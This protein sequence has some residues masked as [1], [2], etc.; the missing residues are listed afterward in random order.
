M[1]DN[2]IIYGLDEIDMLAIQ[3]IKRA[4]HKTILFKG[5]MGSGKTTLIKAIGKKLGVSQKIASPTYSIVNEYEISDGFVYHFDLYRL[6]N[7]EE[8]L[9]FGIEEYLFSEHWKLIE[10][11]DLIQET[12]DNNYTVI[13]IVSLENGLRKICIS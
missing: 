11:P 12:L 9:D 8:A 3:V 1:S 10:W 2:E 7:V 6:K 13:Q 5:E 4:K